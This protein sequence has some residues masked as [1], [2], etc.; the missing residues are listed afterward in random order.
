MLEQDGSQRIRSASPHVRS[1]P[2][3]R[4][5]GRT[6][7][8]GCRCGSPGVMPGH[9]IPDGAHHRF[10]GADE[11]RPNGG[12]GMEGAL[13]TGD[14]GRGANG[15]G[16]ASRRCG[17]VAGFLPM[18]CPLG[19]RKRV[20]RLRR[21]RRPEKRLRRRSVESGQLAPRLSGRAGGSVPGFAAYAG[22]LQTATGRSGQR[23]QL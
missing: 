23:S 21:Y 1:V 16:P 18:G 2:P 14:A 11:T 8:G 20:R 5:T 3:G 4:R 10:G 7:G 13:R 9:G 6:L 12:G 19:G 17:G 22:R 15:H